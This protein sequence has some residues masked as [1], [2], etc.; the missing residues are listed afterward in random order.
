MLL[1]LTLR[2]YCQ[3]GVLSLDPITGAPH[4]ELFIF[5]EHSLDLDLSNAHLL[6]GC[7]RSVSSKL[8][9]PRVVVL[10]TSTAIPLKYCRLP[11]RYQPREPVSLE[12]GGATVVSDSI[13]A[14]ESRH[15]SVATLASAAARDR[16]P[17]SCS[18]R[19][20]GLHG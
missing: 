2:H 8:A 14:E 7:S 12:T 4:R 11:R 1:G 10:T 3:D 15:S 17:S 9:V 6:W 16:G 19:M 20:F 5:D 13:Q 18:V